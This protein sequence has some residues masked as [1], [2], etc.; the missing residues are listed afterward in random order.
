[1]TASMDQGFPR[2]PASKQQQVVANMR[3]CFQAR[4]FGFVD[5]LYLA[6]GSPAFKGD[7]LDCI[8]LQVCVVGSLMTFDHDYT[9]LGDY[10]ITSGI[11]VRHRVEAVPASRTAFQIP[12][13][14]PTWAGG[15]LWQIVGAG[16][17]SNRDNPRAS[18]P[19]SICLKFF[20]S[21]HQVLGGASQRT[22][23]GKTLC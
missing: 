21:P 2:P 20:K 23:T 5:L 13:P 14:S 11:S 3:I 4:Q 10:L 17:R 1:M 7:L 16:V 22:L 6:H 9:P 8:K 18:L 12:R 19:A 15:L